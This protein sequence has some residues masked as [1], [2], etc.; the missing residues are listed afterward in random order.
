MS[1]KWEQV[2][3]WD[4]A[5]LTG[6]WSPL[7]WVLRL[8]SSVWFGVS[9]LVFFAIALMCVSTLA[10]LSKEAG[11][12]RLAI[13]MFLAYSGMAYVLALLSYQLVTLLGG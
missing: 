7:R 3:A 11:S 13:R 1:R 9:L 12:S 2:K 6:G 4:E 5:H 10:I 8:F